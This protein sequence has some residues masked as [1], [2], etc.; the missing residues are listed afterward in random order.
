MWSAEKK[1][2]KSWQTPEI[3]GKEKFFF[4]FSIFK[5]LIANNET[6]QYKKNLDFKKELMHNSGNKYSRKKSLYA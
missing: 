2:D 5:V 3:I 1:M 6:T 4:K